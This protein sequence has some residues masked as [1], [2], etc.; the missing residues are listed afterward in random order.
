MCVTLKD[1]LDFSSSAEVLA[2]AAG[3]VLSAIIAKTKHLKDLGWKTYTRLFETGLVPVLNYSSEISGFKQL[4]NSDNIQSRAIRYYLGVHRFAP[5][6]ALRGEMGWHSIRLTRWLL[7]MLKYW[8]RLINLDDNR[9]SK[10]IFNFS[11]A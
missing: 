9:L 8:N 11:L 7:N 3:R 2:D 10:K 1:N 5:I 4:K 6:P